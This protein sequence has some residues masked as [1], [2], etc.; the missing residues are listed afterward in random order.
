MAVFTMLGT[1][2][3]CSKLLMELL[4]NIHLLG[5]FTIT[6]TLVYRKKAL[7]PIYVYVFLNGLYAGFSPWWIPYLYIWTVLWGLAML[8]PRKMPRGIKAVVYPALCGL[9]GFAFG[10]LYLPAE[11]LIRGM[12]ATQT[13]AWAVAG[14]PFD[15]LH[16]LGN[17]AAGLLILPL[18]TLLF[19][20]EKRK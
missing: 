8:L 11:A 20:L 19:R 5:M 12:D 18:S 14:I 16:G 13:L 4:P 2:M 1:L 7:I 17:L 3:F 10:L 9:H 6:F 15:L